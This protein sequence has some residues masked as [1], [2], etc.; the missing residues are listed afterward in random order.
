VT[1]R[2]RTAKVFMILL[3]F[4]VLLASPIKSRRISKE[5]LHFLKSLGRIKYSN[6]KDARYEKLV[7]MKERYL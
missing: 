2:E 7:E 1:D 4:S 3:Q 5:D 6:I